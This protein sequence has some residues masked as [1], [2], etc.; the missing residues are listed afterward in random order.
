MRRVMWAVLGLAA[1]TAGCGDGSKYAKVSGL[2]TINGKPYPNAV[3]SFQPMA[4]AGNTDPGR[5]SSGETDAH[6][7]FLLATDDGHVGA[8]VG[9]HRVRIMMKHAAGSAPY[10]PSL[11]S[12]DNAPAPRRA[13]GEVDPIPESWN[14]S[15][16][17]EFVVPSGGTDKA[18]FN[19]EN[20]K[21]KN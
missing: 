18:D 13:K 3:V 21:Y 2:I 20:P 9:K 5:G 8:V 14:A 6:G 17:V 7:R 15:S 10:D 19:I 1:M 11:G 16:T 4:T 12:P